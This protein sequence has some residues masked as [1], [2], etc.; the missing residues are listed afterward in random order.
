MF[1]ILTAS[2]DTYITNKILQNK[3]RATD[4]NMGRAGTLDLFRLYD[5]SS[6]VSSGT[7]LTSSVEELTR[8]FVK[9]DYDEL[10]SM[11]SSSLDLNH[12]SFKAMLRLSE[13]KTGAPV[14]K[15]FNVVVYPLAVPFSEGS[16][17]N[18]TQFSDVDA[19]NFVTASYSNGS[20]NLW[21]TSGSGASGYLGDSGVDYYTSGSVGGTE[22]DFGASQ[23]FEDGTGDILVDITSAVSSSL[24]NDLENYGFRI[25]FSGSD[26][27]DS[28]TRFAKRF[29][30]R[31]S[32]NKLIIPRILLTWDDSIQDRHLDLQFNVSSSLF[33]TNTVSG[34]RQNLVSDSS[35][36]ELVGENCVL[37]RFISGSGTNYETSFSVQA[38]QHTASTNGAGMTGV[39]SGTFN[40]SEFNSTFFNTT[41]RSKDEIEL[42]EIWSTNNQ[43][44]GFYTGSITIRKPKRSTSGFSDRRLHV[45]TFNSRTEYKDGTKVVMRIFIEDLD[46]TYNEKAYKLPRRRKSIVVDTAYYRIIDKETG[47]VMVPFDEVNNSTKLSKD[48]DGM[49]FSF[50]TNGLPRGR[51]YGIDLLVADGGIEKLINLDDVSFTVV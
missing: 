23:L 36:T 8:L 30:S 13:V 18:V 16:G 26:E 24:S 43:E 34:E 47:T 46:Q 37:L 7:R 3:F 5:E 20:A 22:I 48:S 44:V 11:T 31:H 25:S 49:Y 12:S 39:Y 32:S 50:Y 14:P 9:F 17:R 45:T 28:K 33:L 2:S 21:N 35:L 51:Q 42:M 1:Y 27:T 10:V 4:S 19:A 41:P 38:S 6:F 15:D 40:L 29:A